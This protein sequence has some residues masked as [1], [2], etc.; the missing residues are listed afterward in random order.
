MSDSS[1]T[2]RE[3]IKTAMKGAAYAAPVILS[4]TIPKAVA[5][6]VSPVP[7]V[8]T[9]TPPVAPLGTPIT[10]PGIGFAPNTFYRTHITSPPPTPLILGIVETDAAGSFTFTATQIGGA[11]TYTIGVS[12]TPTS[13][14][15]ATT[16][17]IYT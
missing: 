3:A 11:G 4:A 9:A 17:Y 13:P 5:A 6:Q 10:I 14:I 8:L 1:A 15:L 2:R 7:P 16:T 12:L